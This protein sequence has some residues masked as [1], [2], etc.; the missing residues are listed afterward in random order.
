MEIIRLLDEL[1]GI[2]EKSKRI[3]MTSKVIIDEDLLFDYLDRMRAM[4]PEEIRQAK[5]ITK[6]R[7]RLLDEATKERERLIE[8]A[9]NY[10]TRMAD[11]SEVAKKAQVFA[12]EIVQQAKKV[13]RE[14]KSGANEYAEDMLK[15]L[16]GTLEKSINVVRKGREEL[17]AVKQGRSNEQASA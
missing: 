3:P 6:E 13:A 5:W 4:L 16:E 2:M 1:E 12:E 10:I 8:D 17:Q 15:S 14:I 7:E 11:E 9:R